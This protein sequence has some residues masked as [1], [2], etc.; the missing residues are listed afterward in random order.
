MK[1]V[2]IEGRKATIDHE[3]TAKLD[4]IFMGLM[5][6]LCD[7]TT[8]VR[9]NDTA[10]AEEALARARDVSAEKPMMLQVFAA[11]GNHDESLLVEIAEQIGKRSPEEFKPVIDKMLA[12]KAKAIGTLH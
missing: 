11:V 7:F 6:A 3:A 4:R 8:A 12:L 5:D 1:V 10:K 9:A 2:Q